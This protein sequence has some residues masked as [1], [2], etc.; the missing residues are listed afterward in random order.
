M[1]DTKQEINSKGKG[2]EELLLPGK[3]GLEEMLEFALSSQ[4]KRGF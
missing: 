3:S 4:E 2:P 1:E